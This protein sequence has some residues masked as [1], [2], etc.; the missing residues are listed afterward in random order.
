MNSRFMKECYKSTLSHI[1]P[2]FEKSLPKTARV[3]ENLF[4]KA[5]HSF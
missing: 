3:Y 5:E 1:C 2:S 4:L